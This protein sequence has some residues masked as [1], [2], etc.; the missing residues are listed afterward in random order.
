MS[1]VMRT[2]GGSVLNSGCNNYENRKIRCNVIATKKN[3]LHLRCIMVVTI[4][5]LMK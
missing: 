3:T 5:L 2:L 1:E 4:T